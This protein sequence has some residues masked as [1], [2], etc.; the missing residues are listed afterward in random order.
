M[1]DFFARCCS[2]WS[3]MMPLLLGRVYAPFCPAFRCFQRSVSQLLCLS[4]TL[5]NC[6]RDSPS[7][8]IE[9]AVL[10]RVYNC[11]K[12]FLYARFSKV[13][14]TLNMWLPPTNFHKLSYETPV[15][16][17]ASITE[18][19]QSSFDLAFGSKSLNAF[20]PASG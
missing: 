15:Y 16:W 14:T 8:G 10:W 2:I 4:Q 3:L 17:L 19:R 12:L 6:E 1:L 18:P 11:R 5:W 9:A 13:P 7:F 20:C